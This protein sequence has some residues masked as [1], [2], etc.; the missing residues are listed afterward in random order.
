MDSG[1]AL[2]NAAINVTM[3]TQKLLVDLEENTSMAKHWFSMMGH[4]NSVGK[5]LLNLLKDAQSLIEMQD[6]DIRYENVVEASTNVDHLRIPTS[7]LTSALFHCQMALVE[8]AIDSHV[9]HMGISNQLRVRDGKVILVSSLRAEMVDELLL[10][11]ELSPKAEQH[12]S[13]ALQMLQ[14]FAIRLTKLPALNGVH[15]IALMWDEQAELSN[16][17]LQGRVEDRGFEMSL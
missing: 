15:A 10:Q 4:D 17:N 7:T 5:N 1:A 2:S 8:N 14:G 16:Q 13:L 9:G 3:L 11:K 6:K 12:L